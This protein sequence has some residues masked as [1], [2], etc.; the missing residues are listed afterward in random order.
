MLSVMVNVY[1]PCP[2]HI[3]RHSFPGRESSLWCML[4]VTFPNVRKAGDFTIFLKVQ[5]P[6]NIIRPLHYF[7]FFLI[8][9]PF[10]WYDQWF[11]GIPDPLYCYKVNWAGNKHEDSA[12]PNQ[13]L[14]HRPNISSHYSNQSSSSVTE[15]GKANMFKKCKANAH[16]A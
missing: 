8:L 15:L 12:S 13:H 2:Q 5:R 11:Q 1:S 3:L 14:R 7:F 4:G 10:L 16:F 6:F 9:I